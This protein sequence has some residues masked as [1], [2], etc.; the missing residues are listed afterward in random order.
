MSLEDLL[1][2]KINIRNPSFQFVLNRAIKNEY[3]KAYYQRPEVKIRVKEYFQRREIKS[4][5]K[6]YNKQYYQKNKKTKKENKEI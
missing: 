4:R 2:E 6:E 1:K 5:I 3:M